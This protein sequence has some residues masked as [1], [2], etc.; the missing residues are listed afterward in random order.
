MCQVKEGQQTE[1]KEYCHERTLIYS[2]NICAVVVI[3]LFGT[4][5]INT[6]KENGMTFEEVLI[7]RQRL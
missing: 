5:E 1:K 3:K 6:I 4:I 7:K 2:T